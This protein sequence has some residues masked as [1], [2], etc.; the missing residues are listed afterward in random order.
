MAKLLN[1]IYEMRDE[2][3]IL[4]SGHSFAM[5]AMMQLIDGMPVYKPP[6]ATILPIIITEIDSVMTSSL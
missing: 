5:I 3:V 2:D 4:Y 6:N 1:Y